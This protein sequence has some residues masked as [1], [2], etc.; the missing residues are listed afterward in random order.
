M[1]RS[2]TLFF[3]DG[4]Q[5]GVHFIK[6]IRLQSTKLCI[7]IQMYIM[8]IYNLF[9]ILIYITGHLHINIYYSTLKRIRTTTH[10]KNKHI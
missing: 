7:Y 4:I 6:E 9:Y 2:Y 10:Q 5:N 8:Y 1:R 3:P